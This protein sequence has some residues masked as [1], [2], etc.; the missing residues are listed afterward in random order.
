MS[1][2]PCFISLKQ[3]FLIMSKR[4]LV[5]FLDE[6]DPTELKAQ[7][8]DLYERF[9]AVKEFYD[10]SFNPN[11]D[12]RI[13]EVKLKISKEY[14]PENGRKAKKRRSIAQKHIVHLQ[15]LEVEP[16]LIT[17]VMLFNI[18]IAQVYTEE[19]WIK[20]E[21]F[22]KS[23]LSSFRKALVFIDKQ[24]LHQEFMGRL[25][26]IIRASI[27]QNWPN[28]EAFVWAKKELLNSI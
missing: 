26:A 28:Q 9:A 20:Q 27:D 15:K 23:M 8:V 10:F 3:G 22:F 18:E 25:D 17:D 4:Q 7:L 12:K 13:R 11:E 6:L 16:S 2:H 21:A 19:Q 24:F 5:R 1:S 14:F